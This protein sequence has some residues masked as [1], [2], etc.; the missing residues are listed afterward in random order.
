[1]KFGISADIRRSDMYGSS[2]GYSIV[3]VL[4]KLSTFKAEKMSGWANYFSYIFAFQ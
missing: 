4:K 1:M 3:K 2:T